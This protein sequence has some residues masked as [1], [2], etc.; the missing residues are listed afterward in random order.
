MA[1]LVI[2]STRCEKQSG[3]GSSS[4]RDGLAAGNLISKW[5]INEFTH[6]EE[7]R[8]YFLKVRRVRGVG[9]WFTKRSS[10]A[11]LMSS[12]RKARTGVISPR[13]I[14]RRTV[15]VETPNSAAA[16]ANL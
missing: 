7:I 15:E 16:S 1:G 11:A 14:A 2:T 9:D 10:S 6:F 13:E 3:N 8:I 4:I 12:V 5:I